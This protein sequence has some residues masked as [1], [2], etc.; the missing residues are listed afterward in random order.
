MVCVF[1]A[2]ICQGIVIFSALAL[3]FHWQN[4]GRAEKIFSAILDFD[5]D[6]CPSIIDTQIESE[7]GMEKQ[8]KQEQAK[9]TVHITWNEAQRAEV[10][11]ETVRRARYRSIPAPNL[12][13]LMAAS[14]SRELPKL[15]ATAL[16]FVS[17][18]NH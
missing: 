3:H 2:L 8:T 5:L 1:L 17:V 6:H 14:V 11:R 18:K 9:K 7:V 4:Q 13:K 10:E 16:R 15:K 12:L